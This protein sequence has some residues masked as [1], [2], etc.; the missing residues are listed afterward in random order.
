VRKFF[1]IFPDFFAKTVPEYGVSVHIRARG[2][3]TVRKKRHPEVPGGK[4]SNVRGTRT[5]KMKETKP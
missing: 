2:R 1:E 3:K 5:P 4:M